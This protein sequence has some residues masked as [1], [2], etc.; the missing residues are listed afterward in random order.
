[1]GGLFGDE[2]KRRN[3]AT[4]YFNADEAFAAM[5]AI[6]WSPPMLPTPFVGAAPRSGN[7]GTAHINAQQIAERLL[8]NVKLSSFALAMV[9]AKYVFV[10]QPTMAQTR[11]P[12]T[13]REKVR[14]EMSKKNFAEQE[15][16]FREAYAAIDTAL[17]NSR[18]T[19]SST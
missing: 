10:L 1:M 11:K 6:S 3:A 14:L 2:D 8:K 15:R 17:E 9:D 7:Y 18:W 13:L 16:Y 19:T 4:A 12:L 5:E